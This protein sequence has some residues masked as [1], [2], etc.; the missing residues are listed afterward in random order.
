MQSGV[1]FAQ[2]Q[3]MGKM[4]CL[5]LIFFAT[6]WAYA[7]HKLQVSVSSEETLRCVQQA[8]SEFWEC[9]G[10]RLLFVGDTI[11]GQVP[12]L[13]HLEIL[14]V[15]VPTRI[16]DLKT[17]KV[18]Y[19]NPQNFQYQQA[20]ALATTAYYRKHNLMMSFEPRLRACVLAD[21]QKLKQALRPVLYQRGY[22]SS[23]I[24]AELDTQLLEQAKLLP[25]NVK[26]SKTLAEMQS[27]FEAVK[28]DSSL[29]YN[30][31]KDGCFAR[32]EIV[33][34]QLVN[35]GFE[36]YKIWI[37]GFSLWGYRLDKPNDFFGW[38]YH[39]APVVKVNGKLWV[40]DPGLFQG[41]VAAHQWVGEVFGPNQKAIVTDKV[42][43][44]ELAA[45]AQVAVSLSAW[46][47]YPQYTSNTQP[48]SDKETSANIEDARL[49][50]EELGL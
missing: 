1:G 48:T 7:E 11:V 44:E 27:A 19:S 16:F 23:E 33:A 31:L 46:Q 39:V 5:I 24:A 32:S 10:K 36:V 6:S 15:K 21:C 37:H 47:M 41:P 25:G 9:D 2:T 35:Q 45:K 13:H 26:T 8:R 38:R 43:E 17:D 20:G 40:F 4:L 3:C 14:D 29:R 12:T 50:L 49:I 42:L 30:Y 28:A 34:A 18:V 22:P